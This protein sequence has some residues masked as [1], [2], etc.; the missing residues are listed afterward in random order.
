MK[1]FLNIGAWT[2][3]ALLLGLVPTAP[4]LAA[5]DTAAKLDQAFAAQISPP[6]RETEDMTLSLLPAPCRVAADLPPGRDYPAIRVD[7]D[8]KG[9][10]VV[11]WQMKAFTSTSTVA[12][13]VLVCDESNN[14]PLV[15]DQSG[16]QITW[17]TGNVTNGQKHIYVTV[18]NKRKGDKDWKVSGL[19]GL[20][21]ELGRKA[22]AM[23]ATIASEDTL[24]DGTGGNGTHDWADYFVKLRWAPL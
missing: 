21:T 18:L 2:G 1:T 15:H 20:Q 8:Q 9:E 23:T 5:S 11:A 13:R 16:N 14:Q 6:P 17:S 4:V 7:L 24:G 3:A 12:Q 10:G 19:R 22:T